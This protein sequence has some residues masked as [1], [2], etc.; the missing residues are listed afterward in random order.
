[1]PSPDA[2]LGDGDGA[3]HRPYLP[4][5]AKLREKVPVLAK[6][7]GFSVKGGRHQPKVMKTWRQVWQTSAQVTQ[8]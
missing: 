2:P 7:A 8:T 5:A 4:E 3:A 1:V 6:K